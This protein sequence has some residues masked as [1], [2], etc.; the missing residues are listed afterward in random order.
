MASAFVTIL[1]STKY[2]TLAAGKEPKST[3]TKD[4]WFYSSFAVNVI[5]P[6]QICLQ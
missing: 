6:S 1:R 2:S 4:N 3:Q 5:L